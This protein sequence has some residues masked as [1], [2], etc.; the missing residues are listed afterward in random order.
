MKRVFYGW[1]VVLACFMVGSYMN[2]AVFLSFTAFFEPLVREYGWTHTQISIAMSLRGFEMSLFTPALGFLVDRFGS[3]KILIAGV[4]TICIGLPLLSV[5]RS[6]GMFYLSFMFL[7]FGAGG[8]GGL[9]T[10][11]VVANWFN[12]NLGKALGIVSSGFGASGVMVP[13]IVWLIDGYGWRA[14]LVLLAIGALVICLP[15][16]FMVREKPE[17]YGLL[18]D[19]AVRGT[20]KAQPK[21]PM[22][23]TI[24]LRE[25]L[26]DRAFLALITIDIMRQVTNSAIGVHIM[27]YLATEG[28]SRATA[29]IVAAAFPLVTILGRGGLG[30]LGDLYDRRRVLALTFCLAALGLLSFCF[31]RL[32][33][34]LV[35]VFLLLLATGLGG[36]NIVG[37]T[38]L[39]EQFGRDYFAR[40]LGIMMGVASIG[41]MIGPTLA[42]WL[43]DTT[44]S[45]YT[46][47]LLFAGTSALSAWLALR[48]GRGRAGRQ[49]VTAPSR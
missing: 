32:G 41:G 39:R 36:S 37:R 2:G 24:P 29:G 26:R 7:S 48:I 10:Q 5:T 16:C 25:A 47:W 38:I 20:R 11:T 4:V 35:L 34:P 33:W 3:R 44:R 46:A 45:Y 14:T 12:K 42:G 21:T 22:A 19:G 40:M 23:A 1:W 13:V 8:C 15:L 9:V 30:W 28:M 27:P 49:A 43:F 6:L 18:P 31:V 17:D